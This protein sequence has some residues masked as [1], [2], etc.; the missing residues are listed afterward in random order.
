MSDVTFTSK[1]IPTT[2]KDYYKVVEKIDHAN[3]INYPWKIKDSKLAQQTFTNKICDCSACIIKDNNQGLLMHLCPSW[4]EN[5]SYSA[6][7]D[8]VKNKIDLKNKNLTAVL[9]GSKNTKKSLDTYEML[10]RFLTNFKI[11]FSELKNGKKPTNIAY[12]GDLDEIYITNLQI[13]KVLSKGETPQNALEKG[14]EKINI[15]E[16]DNI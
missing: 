2:S 15:S 5:H 3:A 6:L 12:R 8:F 10:K 1:I 7:L 16:F 4:E 9:I 11:P 14:F 13:D